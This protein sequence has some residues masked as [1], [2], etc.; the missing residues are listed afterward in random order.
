MEG[1]KMN[2]A[3][4][5]KNY[6][7]HGLLC[8][9]L[10]LAASNASAEEYTLCASA[11][12]KT[13][14]D[15]SSVPMWGYAKENGIAT[16]CADAPQV[17]GPELRVTT[18]SLTIHL[19]NDLTEPTSLV[20]PGQEM[21]TSL[22]SGPTW[23]DGSLPGSR[24]ANM[25]A[26][27]AN[28][29]PSE[30]VKRVR[31]F[32]AE[33]AAGDTQDYV[34]AAGEIGN[35][36]MIYHSG[37]HPQKQLYMGLY[38]AVM[39][40]AAAGEAYAGV[41][42]NDEVVL[43]YSEID[44]VL[45]RSIADES[46]E[47]SIAYH[48]QWFL[49]NGEPYEDGVTA[50]L[51]AGDGLGAETTLIRF[52]SAAGET[53]VPVLQGMH[54]SII[55][56]DGNQYGYQIGAGAPIAAPREQY[57][58]M[59]PPLKTKD[60]LLVNP[61]PGRY[62]VYDGNG[63][64]TNP[65]NP[66]DINIGDTVGGMLRFLQVGAAPSTD[67]DEDGVFDSVDNCPA[68]IN[69][70]QE[71]ADFD[72]IGDVCDAW[73]NDPDN[74]VD[75]D[76]VSGE[77]D[78][79]PVVANPADLLTGLQADADSDGIGDACDDDIDDDTV[80]NDADNCP[81]DANTDQADDDG[82]GIGNVCDALP[83][84]GDNDGIDDGL[85][86]CPA[87]PNPGQEDGDGDLIGDACDAYPTDPNNDQDGDG[88]AE[89]LDNCPVTANTDQ[90]DSDG[91]GAGNVCDLWPNDPFDD[92][93]GDGI[94]GE[95]DNCPTD[96]NANQADADGD[97]TGDV[98]DAFPNDPDN[99]IDN[100]GIGGDVDNCP[101]DYNP[102]QEDS[103]VPPNGIGDA[104]DV[105]GPTAV[106]DAYFTDEDAAL[107]TVAANGVLSNDTGGS[108]TLT[109]SVLTQPANG[110]VAMVS[111]GSFTYTPAQ[112]WN[113]LI[114]GGPDTFTYEVCD[115]L[116]ACATATVS[117]TVAPIND[118]PVAD[119][120]TVWLT[121]MD[122]HTGLG[123]VL[124]ND[125]DVDG[126]TMTAVL[127]ADANR[128]TLSLNSGGTFDYAAPTNG[129]RAG[130]IATF[131]YAANDGTESSNVVEVTI[132]RE[133]SVNSAS[134]V[135]DDQDLC[136]WQIDGRAANDGTILSTDV[137]RA[138]LNGTTEIGTTTKGNGPGWSIDETGNT[139]IPAPG[140]TV[141]VVIDA[142]PNAIITDFTVQ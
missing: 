122:P 52:L 59:M 127:D 138:L 41:A 111:D 22:T 34:W 27:P 133:L 3:K 23:N 132:R 6:I 37:T 62:A 42:Y 97:G 101:V 11:F 88:I 136:A 100:D 104:C 115:L 94:S 5:M 137:I 80:L 15:G 7:K 124:D 64:M 81:V 117:V 139:V 123:S 38:G 129:T 120:D 9:F 107:T 26:Y 51:A 121:T 108:G 19:V 20:I 113:S 25:D 78:N 44:P 60:A 18:G 39:S 86:N 17:P 84:D 13:L 126:D 70:G 1:T 12:T 47:T 89:P 98:C 82:D 119:V 65:S 141:T 43:F 55:A 73:P 66:D 95:L 87:D 109:A 77:L 53:H 102:G 8:G 130:V 21:P 35:G 90:L 28:C 79:C 93:D 58:A 114:G 40:D 103:D 92:I 110:T 142:V 99:D 74:D 32:G 33:A 50:D 54:M 36:T 10:S 69:P 46:Y 29:D 128:G 30:M 135:I 125:T 4:T 61:A 112:D 72:G 31:S 24:C 116:A 68:D 118:A 91:D 85:D 14:P 45:N 2:K 49:V 106:D 16:S 48:A 57:S 71:D 56:E 131:D 134:C 96:V 83:N 75:N 63:Y 76:G 67:S 140:D 105:A